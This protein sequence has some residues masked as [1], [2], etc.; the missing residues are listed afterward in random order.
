MTE[1]PGERFE[2]ERFNLTLTL[3]YTYTYIQYT[4]A[5]ILNSTH[6]PSLER[7]RLPWKLLVL[8]CLA[9]W[10]EAERLLPPLLPPLS[11]SSSAAR[12]VEEARVEVPCVDVPRDFLTTGAP[13][14]RS[15]SSWEKSGS[16]STWRLPSTMTLQWVEGEVGEVGREGRER[17]S[18]VG[19]DRGKAVGRRERGRRGRRV[20]R[21]E[22]RVGEGGVNALHE[23]LEGGGAE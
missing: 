19:S 3:T 23:I 16:C 18:R 10:A 13:A 14:S 9:L 1:N 11:G 12:W 21:V 15:S 4:I 17:R 22:Q 7:C 6:L 2:I 20:E 5:T 8:E